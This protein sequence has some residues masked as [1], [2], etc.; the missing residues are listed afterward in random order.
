MIL[1]ILIPAYNEK[2]TIAEILERIESVNLDD[3]SFEKEIIIIDDG[4]TDGTKE[5]LNGLEGKYKIIYHS[6]N[7]GKG[8]AI[9]TGLERASGDY[10]IIQDADLE[11]DPQDYR[12]MIESAIKNRAQAVYGSRRLNPYNKPRYASYYL[13]GIFLNWMTR[14]IS[15]I[16]ITD[17]STCYK[18][19]KTELI[20]SL[21][22]KCE[23]FDFCPEVTM[24]I[25]K[26]GIKIYEVP[27]SYHPRS[28]EEGKK[29]KWRDGLRALVAL[30]KYKFFEK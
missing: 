11:Y 30:I 21:A 13:G 1:S 24:K 14:L 6:Q 2:K 3:I 18:L 17:E 19:F 27:I 10:V 12:K 20:K 15:G 16:K 28:I 22:L 5:I 23:G 25:A 4:S 8:A 9:R 26:R 29:I 7:K